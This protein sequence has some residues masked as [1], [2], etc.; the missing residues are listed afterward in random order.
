MRNLGAQFCRICR[1]V[2]LNRIGPLTTAV[3][4]AQTPISVVARYPSHLDVFAVGPTGGPS[5]TGG[6]SPVAGP[7][8]STS[9][10][11]SRRRV[12]KARR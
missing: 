10:A 2:I 6:T 3:V 9:P 5:P 1:Q 4:R 11:A 7:A 12:V 8:G